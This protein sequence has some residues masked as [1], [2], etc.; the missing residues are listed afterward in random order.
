MEES[1]TMKIPNKNTHMLFWT[2]VLSTSLTEK[3]TEN[4]PYSKTP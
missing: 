2:H 1:K 4:N 3:I